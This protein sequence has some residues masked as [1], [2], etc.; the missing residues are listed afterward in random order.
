MRFEG[1]LYEGDGLIRPGPAFANDQ[2]GGIET[3]VQEPKIAQ[4][5]TRPER[6]VDLVEIESRARKMR[7]EFIGSWL[8]RLGAWVTGWL[9]SAS[10]RRAEEYLA[11]AQSHAELESRMRDLERRGYVPHL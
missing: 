8:A 7:A 11:R 2:R 9:E 6:K 1:P 10:R 4:R 3:A 5:S